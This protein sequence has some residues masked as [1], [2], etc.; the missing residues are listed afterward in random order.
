MPNPKPG[1]SSTVN[2]TPM[3]E[4]IEVIL[5]REGKHPMDNYP[6]NRDK[7]AYRCK[8]CEKIWMT[9]KEANF[10]ICIPKDD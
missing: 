3:R 2:T 10:H 9:K 4:N 7:N 1:I 8:L 5:A 6:F